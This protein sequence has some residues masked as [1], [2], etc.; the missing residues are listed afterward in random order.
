MSFSGDACLYKPMHAR[1]LTETLTGTY[2]DAS[3]SQ[4][5]TSCAAGKFT[6][7]TGA[8][9]CDECQTGT[10]QDGQAATR[11]KTCSWAWDSHTWS[12]ITASKGSTHVT[13]CECKEGNTG[14]GVGVSQD[15]ASN[16]PV[17]NPLTGRLSNGGLEFSRT[18]AQYLHSAPR[19]WRINTNGGL[20]IVAEIKF[21]GIVGEN[22]RI[23]DFGSTLERYYDSFLFSRWQSSDQVYAAITEKVVL[24]LG[25]PFVQLF[26]LVDVF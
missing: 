3:G 12:T 22:E 8:T 4:A 24:C 14:S 2:K 20:T 1:R 6:S 16:R 26:E 25:S 11:C 18:A 19:T 21:S 10:Y 5:C 15:M 9:G 17:Y 7:S 13:A 23:I